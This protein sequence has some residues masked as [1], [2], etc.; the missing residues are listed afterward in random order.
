MEKSRLEMTPFVTS[1]G[2]RESPAHFPHRVYRREKEKPVRTVSLLTKIAICC[3]VLLLVL[4]AELL[5]LPDEEAALETAAAGLEEGNTDD[6]LGKL[7]FVSAGSAV[8]VFS[9]SQR[10]SA[11]VRATE[12]AQIDEPLMLRLSAAAGERVS[13][14]AAGEVRELGHDENYGDFVRVGH[15]D[16][17]E[18][19]YYNIAAIR[20]EEGQPLLARDTLGVVPEDGEIYVSVLLEGVAQQPED[21]VGSESW[22]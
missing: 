11:P 18:S 12:T 2:R 5:L 6:A 17:L 4:V 7:Q 8:S 3:A 15:G 22:Y 20:V 19:V 13:L 1:G 16:G 14:P 9:A 21:Y 10:W